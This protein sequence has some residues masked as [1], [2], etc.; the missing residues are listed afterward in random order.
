MSVEAYFICWINLLDNTEWAIK[1]GHSRETVNKPSRIPKEQSK[2]D[3]QEKLETQG[4]QDKKKNTT[5][6]VQCKLYK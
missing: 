5:Q 1:N 4:T 2:M 6:Y 3:N